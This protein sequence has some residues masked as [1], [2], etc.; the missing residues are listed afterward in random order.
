MCVIPRERGMPN[1]VRGRRGELLERR[2]LQAGSQ[3]TSTQ[4]AAVAMPASRL[5]PLSSLLGSLSYLIGD[6]M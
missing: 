4:S 3:M 2:P 1:H 5:H 6:L